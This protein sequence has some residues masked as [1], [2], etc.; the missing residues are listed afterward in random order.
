MKEKKNTEWKT[1]GTRTQKIAFLANDENALT[2]FLHSTD[3]MLYPKKQKQ[4]QQ[5][6]TINVKINKGIYFGEYMNK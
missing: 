3:D 1:K 2:T 4:K 6:K 5:Q